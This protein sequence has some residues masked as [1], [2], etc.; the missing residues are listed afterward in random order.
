MLDLMALSK[1][2]DI[3]SVDVKDSALSH[4]LCMCFNLS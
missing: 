3:F 1:G 4:Y 2:A